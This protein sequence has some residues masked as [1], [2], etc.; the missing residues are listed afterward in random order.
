MIEPN[1][2]KE[3]FVKYSL[4]E[5]TKD[6]FSVRLNKEERLWLNEVKE[7]LNIEQDSKALKF[8]ALIGR[9]VLQNTFSRPVLKYLFKKDR[10][11]LEDFK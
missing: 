11:K 3:P 5:S 10:I 4:E 7:D 8:C 9:N 6:V 1:I 2:E